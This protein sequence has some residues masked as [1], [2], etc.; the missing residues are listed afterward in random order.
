MRS[1][2]LPGP[3]AVG[4]VFC[5]AKLPVV[6]GLVAY[7]VLTGATEHAGVSAYIVGNLAFWFALGLAFVSWWTRPLGRLQEALDRGLRPADLQPKDLDR[8]YG[9]GWRLAWFSVV[10]WLVLT[11]GIPVV[12]SLG[13]G[14]GGAELVRAVGAGLTGASLTPIAVWFALSMLERY[15]IS[16]LVLEGS[17]AWF[18]DRP[19]R[20]YYIMANVVVLPAVGLIGTLLL[21]VLTDQL[22][23]LVVVVLSTIYFATLG[24]TSW[25]FSQLLS[26]ELGHLRDRMREVKDGDLDAVARI[27]APDTVGVVASGFNEML[28]GLRQREFIRETFGRYVSR[29]VADEIL[30]GDVELGGELRT[31]TMLFSDIRGFTAM[32]ESLSPGEVVAF[33]NEYLN[34]MVTAVFEHGGTPDK[35]IGDAIMATFGVPVTAGDPGEDARAAVRCAVAMSCALEE[36]NAARVARGH[37]PIEI[38]IGV[39]TG[40]VVAGNIGS[41]QRMEYT[42]IGDAVN[43]TSRIEGL[44]KS[45]GRRILISDSTAAFLEGTVELVEVAT[46]PVRGRQESVRL[47]T[48]A[49]SCAGLA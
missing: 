37:A 17:P 8:A 5:A 43:L 45:V 46:L 3:L 27:G 34:A 29:Q 14:L 39:H 26:R 13:G 40:E 31:V 44:T 42:V 4:A 24:G 48:V 18:S 9:I 25:A 19:I 11:A 2:R 1:D 38:G 41:P 36:L 7:F 47:F 16:P 21:L 49:S 28:E 6:A 32:S 30:S 12:E 33:L 10:E 22:S 35:F 20:P 15:R 23:G